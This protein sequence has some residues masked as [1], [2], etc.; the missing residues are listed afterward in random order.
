MKRLLLLFG[1]AVLSAGHSYAQLEPEDYKYFNHLSAGV[2]VG[3]D[4]IGIDIAA[5]LTYNFALRAGYTFMPK[6]TYSTTIDLNED[7]ALS[8]YEDVGVQGRLKMGDFH[9]LADYY[10][11]KKSSF[12]LTAG[13]Y[14][15]RRNIVSVYNTEPFVK[16]GY[17]GN[18]GIEMGT[19]DNLYSQYTFTTDEKGDAQ[20][21]AKANC[22]KPY[23]GIGFGRAVTKHRVCVQFDLGVQFWGRPEAWTNVKYFDYEQG[24]Y[25]TG[26]QKIDRNRITNPNKDYQDVRDGMRKA[27][28]YRIYP[29]LKVRINGRIF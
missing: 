12:H 19:T 10:P 6:I 14:I 8:K 29:I 24:D 4:G 25:V 2:S 22:F 21:E 20:V 23:V 26:Y 28:K 7:K 9:L 13:A 11:F 16:E 27:E 1:M 15:G 17:W 18:A 3:L 5:P